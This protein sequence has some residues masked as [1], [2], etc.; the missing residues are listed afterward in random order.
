MWGSI[1]KDGPGP[2]IILSGTMTAAKYIDILT[3]H[4]VPFKDLIS[5]FQHD[6]APAHKAAVVQEFLRDNEIHTIN[7]PPYSPDLNPIFVQ[8]IRMLKRLIDFFLFNV[9][10]NW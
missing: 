8:L 2:L 9:Q 1:S 3:D 5:S 4:I 6:N 10:F 7:W